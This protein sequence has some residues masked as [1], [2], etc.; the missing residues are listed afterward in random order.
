MKKVIKIVFV[1][2]FVMVTGYNVYKSNAATDRFTDFMLANVE[3]LADPDESGTAVGVCYI[4][5]SFASVSD[6]KLFC[7]SQTGNDRIYPC[8][9]STS[10]GG[11]SEMLKDRCTK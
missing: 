8:P 10:F 11:Y 2:V 5:Q 3:A 1:A 7:D 4:S 6:F 9:S